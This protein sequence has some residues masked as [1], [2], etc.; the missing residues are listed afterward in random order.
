MLTRSILQVLLLGLAGLAF[1]AVTLAEP[2]KGGADAGLA[3]SLRKAQGM[4]RQ[5]SQEKADLEA[6]YADLE[7]QL[8]EMKGRE[9]QFLKAIKALETK[10]AQVEPLQKSLA[11]TKGALQSAQA[12]NTNLQQQLGGQ[13]TRLQSA[14]EQQ[15]Q[16]VGALALQKRDN[17]LLVNAVK[18]RTRWIQECTSRNRALVSANK[19]MLAKFSDKSFWDNFKESEPM[20]GLGSIAKEN[21]QQEFEYKFSDLEVT[22]W[23][24]PPADEPP[25]PEPAEPSAKADSG[26]Q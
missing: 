17:Q 4:L 22:P 3:Q 14:T 25:P 2:P 10:A 18:E 21:A 1:S 12:S 15:R 19:E 20:T 6:K 9:E 24:D 23:Q 13:T 11:D 26:Q 7:K 8:N 5:I 16:T